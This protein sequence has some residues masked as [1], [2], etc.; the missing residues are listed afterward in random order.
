MRTKNLKKILK[1]TGITKL[2]RTKNPTVG[3][4]V[5][6]NR[7]QHTTVGGSGVA[8]K[9]CLLPKPKRKVAKKSQYNLF[10]ASKKKAKEN[11]FNKKKSKIFSKSP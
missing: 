6:E 7:T 3:G 8:T 4:S 10:I 1:K 5:V 2:S 11:F 9:S